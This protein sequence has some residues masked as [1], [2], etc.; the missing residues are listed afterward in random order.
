M[1]RPRKLLGYRAQGSVSQAS[2][3]AHWEGFTFSGGPWQ[4]IYKGRW[5][6]LQV[7]ASSTTEGRRVIA[8]ACSHAGIS[9][10]DPDG[11]WQEARSSHPRHQTVRQFRT[12]VRYGAPVV[13]VRDGPAGP[14]TFEP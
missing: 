10:N 5:G 14:P 13:T 11:Y 2:A 1:G 12:L 3:A 7:W 8:H 6:Q 9:T 4:V